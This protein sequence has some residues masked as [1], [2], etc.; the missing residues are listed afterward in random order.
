MSAN[1]ASA[2]DGHPLR[3]SKHQFFRASD[4]ESVNLRNRVPWLALN[5]FQKDIFFGGTHKRQTGHQ[6][7]HFVFQKK[8]NVV[9]R[10]VAKFFPLSLSTT[11]LRKKEKNTREKKKINSRIEKK[12]TQQMTDP[13]EARWFARDIDSSAPLVLVPINVAQ[14][15]QMKLE[16]AALNKSQSD[17]RQAVLQLEQQTRADMEALR[18]A[19][20][21]F[22]PP[23]PQRQSSLAPV[24]F[25]P[26][27][28][29]SAPEDAILMS[30]RIENRN[31]RQH[32]PIPFVP[33]AHWSEWF[34]LPI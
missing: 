8:K 2:L 28:L 23:P 26:S 27:S 6:E 31:L 17:L 25:T 9:W 13:I 30:R 3:A 33:Q 18:V 12:K 4:E 1:R 24:R 34:R 22:P 10:K 21:R 15:R 7:S 19:L 29:S 16:C 32:R 20:S 11:T 5:L 14:L